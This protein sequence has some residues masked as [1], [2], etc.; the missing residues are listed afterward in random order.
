MNIKQHSCHPLK[1]CCLICP[2]CKCEG[3]WYGG[4]RGMLTE[5]DGHI[6]LSISLRF[7]FLSTPRGILNVASEK[8]WK[9]PLLPSVPDVLF[10]LSS[11]HWR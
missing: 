2:P 9:R 10:H 1:E 11:Q 3:E 8:L 6:C 7:N 4:E 5:P